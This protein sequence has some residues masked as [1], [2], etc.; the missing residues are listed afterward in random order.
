MGHSLAVIVSA[1]REE[2]VL[3]PSRVALLQDIRGRPVLGHVLE[4]VAGL[5]PSRVL[6]LIDSDDDR[7][8]GYESDLVVFLD[9]PG[10]SSV[11]SAL[12]EVV[13]LSGVDAVLVAPADM[14]LLSPSL[15]HDFV[16]GFN[17]SK[18]DVGLIT[19][20]LEP[21]E[22][23]DVVERDEQGRP[24][25]VVREEPP[26]EDGL[27]REVASG[28]CLV[29]N[30]PAGKNGILPLF[31]RD[32]LDIPELV[33]SVLTAGG[34]LFAFVAR[35]QHRVMRVDSPVRLAEATGL[36]GLDIARALM[37]A[38]VRIAD[39]GRTYVDADVKIGADSLLLPG[40]H[41]CGDCVLGESCRIGPDTWVE[42]SV[43]EVGCRVWYSVIEKARIRS[44][45]TVGPYAH[46]RPGADV[47][48]N[49]RIGN[50]VEVK[51]SRVKD[52]AKVG[53][54]SY[55]GDSEVGTEVNIGA[56]T[57]TCNYDGERKHRTTVGD[58]AF[59][60]SNASLVAPVI[61]GE[62]AIVGAG[63]VITQDVPPGALALG[64]TR[65]V[66]KE[67]KEEEE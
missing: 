50:F 11:A 59:I 2:G 3:G 6:V 13:E 49:V 10:E 14:P 30:C 1:R 23:C 55:L 40:S 39:P 21:A 42:D 46:L 65:Q 61:I 45:T 12:S 20:F 38:G 28:V 41:I 37:Q 62:G 29:R 18:A 26:G 33:D 9:S 48:P 8:A 44:G 7:F 25:R 15:L 32:N 43:V 52:G 17:Q 47:G 60:G 58:R 36:M 24:V 16:N 31:A 51:A 53:H 5:Q 22:C 19:A 35:D 56:G 63:S 57:I 64:R 54:L 66:N 34:E 4:A 67:R 27:R